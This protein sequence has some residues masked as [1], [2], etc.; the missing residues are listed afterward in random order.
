MTPRRDA[1]T[2]REKP[3]KFRGAG[4]LL[5]SADLTGGSRGES[6]AFP[7]DAVLVEHPGRHQSA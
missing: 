1:E 5:R 7:E 2:C 3:K 6:Q 4:R